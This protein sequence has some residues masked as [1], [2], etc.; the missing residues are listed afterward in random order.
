MPGIRVSE[1]T[2]KTLNLLNKWQGYSTLDELLANLIT[3]NDRGNHSSPLS[4]GDT[5]TNFVE[6][7]ETEGIETESTGQI[8]TGPFPELSPDSTGQISRDLTTLES[9]VENGVEYIDLSNGTPEDFFFTKIV[10]A[11]IDNQVYR[12]QKWS[13]ILSLLLRNI[14]NRGITNIVAVPQYWVNGIKTT[15][16]WQYFH[17]MKLSIHRTDAYRTWQQIKN[18][19][20]KY[21]IPVEIK[22]VWRKLGKYPSNKGILRVKPK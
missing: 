22:V 13:I 18:L 10:F 21:K 20:H 12:D 7:I 6:A 17:D 11:K 4:S 5:K 16:G 19:A 15:G 14:Q 8:T 9:I 1:Q 2:Y 3:E